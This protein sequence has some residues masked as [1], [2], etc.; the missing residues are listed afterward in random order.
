MQLQST[1]S[2]HT[3]RPPGLSSKSHCHSPLQGPKQDC[4][5]H[6]PSH[7]CPSHH[8]CPPTLSADCAHSPMPLLS[9]SPSAALW[10]FFRSATMV[11]NK[12]SHSRNTHAL[13]LPPKSLRIAPESLKHAT[14]LLMCPS[15]RHTHKISSTA[16]TPTPIAKSLPRTHRKQQQHHDFRRHQKHCQI[17][18]QPKR[19]SRKNH[20]P[21][22]PIPLTTRIPTQQRPF[23]SRKHCHLLH[24]AVPDS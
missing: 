17:F 12:H 24:N 3:A 10:C 15:N 21:R 1:G 20:H 6:P 18:C 16:A 23:K 2:L 19:K 5:H 8:C 7:H 11:N 22:L 13:R 14:L 9:P 4:C